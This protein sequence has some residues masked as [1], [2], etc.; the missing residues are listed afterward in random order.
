MTRSLA[1]L[2]AGAATGILG[3]VLVERFAFSRL[4]VSVLL[5]VLVCLVL[6]GTRADLAIVHQYRLRARRKRP[7]IGILNDMEWGPGILKVSAWTDISPSEWQREI[8]KQARDKGMKL[9]VELMRTSNN[10][11]PYTVV[12]NP[13]GGTYPERDLVSFQT[14]NNIFQYV[15]EGGLFVN[16]ADIP[17]YWAY[18]SMLRK[19]TETAPPVW[20][21]VSGIH[22]R[23]VRPFTVVPWMQ[24]LGLNVVNVE[25]VF[26]QPVDFVFDLGFLSVTDSKIP[27]VRL[28]RLAIVE[29]NMEVVHKVTMSDEAGQRKELASIFW[30]C[31]GEGSF[32]ISLVF[33]S[34]QSQTVKEELRK[35]L[36]SLI[37]SKL[38]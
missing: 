2:L 33:L 11:D 38:M 27:G 7:K 10:F 23:A 3:S 19:R 8:E 20:D 24:K 13:Y 30:F 5:V 1:L 12:V 18:H 17:G 6:L 29:E 26:R 15:Q 21:V 14:L 32:L 31:M 37:L 16:V 28:H 35:V 36:V 9:R 25:A 4:L 22:L 34:S